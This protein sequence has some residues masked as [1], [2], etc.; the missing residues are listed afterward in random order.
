L[1]S[2]KLQAIE[3]PPSTN[4]VIANSTVVINSG[5]YD[6]SINNN[7]Y[8]IGNTGN[9]THGETSSTSGTTIPSSVTTVPST[10]QNNLNDIVSKIWGASSNITEFILVGDAGTIFSSTDMKNFTSITSNTTN[11]L[12]DIACNYTTCITV[13]NSGTILITNDGQNF[14]AATSGTTQNLTSITAT[15]DASSSWTAS[16]SSGAV[17]SSDNGATWKSSNTS[18]MSSGYSI[19]TMASTGTELIATVSS[20]DS[21]ATNQLLVSKDQGQSFTQ[22]QTVGGD[23]GTA[24][25]LKAVYSTGT[26]FVPQSASGATAGMTPISVGVPT[27]PSITY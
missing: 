4:I 21:T 8:S 13:G 20:T 23:K 27:T 2:Y 12:N 9:I 15:S 1:N 19:G 14:R 10:T 7:I 26:S 11:N 3:S 24:P 16:G 22:V 17:Y 25:G 6:G 18:S 5:S